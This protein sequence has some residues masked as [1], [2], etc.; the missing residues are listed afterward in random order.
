MGR[1]RVYPCGGNFERSR[2]SAII[3]FFV[4]FVL[5]SLD[6]FY[7]YPSYFVFVLSELAFVVSF[8]VFLY[9][10][11]TVRTMMRVK[12]L[13][14]GDSCTDCL[15]NFFCTPCS[16]AQMAAEVDVE[17]PM[18]MN[19]PAEYISPSGSG[20]NVTQYHV[21]TPSQIVVVDT[22]APV[23]AQPIQAVVVGEPKDARV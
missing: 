13:I 8:A 17:N 10:M 23:Y 5:Y 19:E 18:S 21:A 9:Q 6:G 12:Y 11:N 4:A 7:T 14:D 2:N 16:I 15:L 20:V 22:Q 3:S 1:I